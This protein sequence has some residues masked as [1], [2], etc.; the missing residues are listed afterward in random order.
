MK[1]ITTHTLKTQQ[2]NIRTKFEYHD[3]IMVLKASSAKIYWSILKT[4]ANGKNVPIVPP[5]LIHGDFNSDFQ[6]KAYNF[7]KFF[8]QQ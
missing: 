3:I 8:S 6:A 4:F 7:N 5:L 1:K 2:P